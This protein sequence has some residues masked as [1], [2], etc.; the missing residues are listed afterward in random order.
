[1]LLDP[2]EWQAHVHPPETSPRSN[3][4]PTPGSR[5]EPAPRFESS[6][7]SHPNLA[8]TFRHSGW[9]RDRTRIYQALQDTGQSA[10]R[11]DR[12]AD[13]GAHAYVYRC[14]EDPTL[15][16]VQGSTCRDRFCGPCTRERGQTIAANITAALNGK[17]ARF[18]TLTLRTEDLPLDQALAKLQRAFRLLLRTK[19]WLGRVDG[20]VA[21][22]EVK[23]N[24]HRDRWH[25]HIHAIVQGR[26]IPF[27][28][29]RKEWLRITTDSHVVR[30]QVVHSAEVILRY[31]TTYASKTL[32]AADFP[33]TPSLHEAVD[34]L[35]GTRLCRTF[36]TWRGMSLTDTPTS[37]TW[38]P[39]ASLAHVLTQALAGDIDAR[40]IVAALPGPI[41]RDWL[42]S[43]PA[44]PP[45]V[46]P[47]PEA[48]PP[49]Q[50]RLD[51]QPADL[52]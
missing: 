37:G 42:N 1:M 26:Y 2:A 32:R 15:L 4:R 10:G 25:P 36:G 27:D 3:H 7:I 21:F 34:A 44:R 28:L 5:V 48:A 38:E 18:V 8:E 52:R 46:P 39:V 30:V 13:C 31:V 50:L 23:Y 47:P 51:L 20:G 49:Q 9:A 45:P 14:V 16:R 22:I 40:A 11:I 24:P 19:L 29:L 12:F 33:T 17:R 41:P 35:H 6:G 43:H